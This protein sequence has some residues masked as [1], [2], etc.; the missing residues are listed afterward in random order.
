MGQACWGMHRYWVYPRPRGG[1]MG[2]LRPFDADGRVYPR[3][4]GGTVESLGLTVSGPRPRGG[5]RAPPWEIRPPRGLSPPTRGN[6]S[7]AIHG[8]TA[9]WSI[10]AHA[11]EPWHVSASLSP[12]RV[13]PRPRGGTNIVAHLVH[14]RGRL[15]PP[16]RGEPVI[17]AGIDALRRVYPRPRGGTFFRN[18]FVVCQQ[19]LSPP[20]RGNLPA[21][22]H[23][24]PYGSIPAHAGEPGGLVRLVGGYTVYPRPRGGTVLS[25]GTLLAG[26]GLSPPTRGN[27]ELQIW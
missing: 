9:A 21:F 22:A 3:P 27:L 26:V 1:T 4:R 19:G 14:S 6:H 11:G 7:L 25:C 8:R 17:G 2:K 12:K 5:T 24:L 15:S 13:Y 16:T 10:P 23:M 20:T 18:R